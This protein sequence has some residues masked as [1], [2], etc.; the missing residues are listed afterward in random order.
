[1]IHCNANLESLVSIMPLLF[2][3]P[4][5]TGNTNVEVSL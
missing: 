4:F 2:G 1:M 3:L 5:D